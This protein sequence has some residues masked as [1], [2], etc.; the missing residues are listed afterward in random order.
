[1]VFLELDE[2]TKFDDIEGVTYW[3]HGNY[4]VPMVAFHGAILPI[5]SDLRVGIFGEMDL[6]L[7]SNADESWKIAN[8]IAECCGYVANKKGDSLSIFGENKQFV[9]F[10]QDGKIHNIEVFS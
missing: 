8:H 10:Y 9:V 6:P 7:Y 5:N 1:M 2:K 4:K 3:R